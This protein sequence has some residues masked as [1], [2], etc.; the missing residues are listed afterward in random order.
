MAT[1]APQIPS[2]VTI[3]WK[4]TF[5]TTSM[6]PSNATTM[7]STLR[8]V[9]TTFERRNSKQW[10]VGKFICLIILTILTHYTK[11]MAYTINQI[12]DGVLVTGPLP[13]RAEGGA[14]TVLVTIEKPPL[15]PALPEAIKDL[16][17]KLKYY[18]WEGIL[19]K[20][21]SAW[22]VRYSTM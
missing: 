11:T 8:S 22:L 6:A 19:S 14:W 7:G 4:P 13:L 18:D 9:A 21:R 15:D 12:K 5:N 3:E 16:T 2:P 20:D 1:I 17:N 10:T